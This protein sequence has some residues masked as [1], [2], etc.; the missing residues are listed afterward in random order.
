MTE[1]DKLYSEKQLRSTIIFLLVLLLIFIILTY[2]Y[3]F[4]IMSIPIAI[5]ISTIFGVVNLT[6]NQLKKYETERYINKNVQE[7]YNENKTS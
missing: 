2:I 3:P 1:R 7:L 4:T 5:T 6:L